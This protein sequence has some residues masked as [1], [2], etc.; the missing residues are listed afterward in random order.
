MVFCFIND[1]LKT[2]TILLTCDSIMN[3]V[4]L[5]D[6]AVLVPKHLRDRIAVYITRNGNVRSNSKH[7]G[8][9]G[10]VHFHWN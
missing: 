4:I 10:D 6:L 7:L 8:L 9:Q 5:D 1:Q 3:A 2:S